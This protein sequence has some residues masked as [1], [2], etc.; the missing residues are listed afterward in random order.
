MHALRATTGAVL[1]WVNA[2]VWIVPTLVLALAALIRFVNLGHPSNLVF[3]EVYYVRDA[4]SQMIFGFPTEWPNDL[5]YAFGPEEL[6]RMSGEASYAVHPPLGKWLIA[7]GL[8]LFGADNGWGWRFSAALVGTLTVAL[9]MLLTHRLTRSVWVASL[10][11]L[12]L[13]IEG[14][15]VVLSRVSLLDGFLTFFALLG[16]LFMVLD[17]ERTQRRFRLD[18][19]QWMRASRTPQQPFPVTGRRWGPV[20]WWRPWLFAAA[21]AFGC[22]SAVKWSGLYFFLAFAVFTVIADVVTRRRLGIRH[23]LADGL[24]RQTPVA[25]LTTVPLLL[26]TYLASWSGWIFTSGGWNRS[27]ATE[28]GATDPDRTGQLAWLPDWLPSLW[29]YHV[30]MFDWHS[31]LQAAHPYLAHPLTWLPALRPTSMF[32]ET[33]HLGAE[34]CR[35]AECA[36]AITPIPNVLIWWGGVAAT[37]WLVVWLVRRSLAQRTLVRKF[38]TLQPF[39]PPRTSVTKQRFSATRFAPNALMLDRATVFALVGF[40]AGYAPWLITTSRT[41]VFQFYTVVF[42]PYLVLALTLVLWRLIVTGER[43]GGD[44]A[45]SRRWMVGVFLAATVLISAYF[46]PLWTGW[47]IPFAYWNIHMWL[48]GWR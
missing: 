36:M 47:P 43:A 33:S 4:A 6:A 48:P 11:G 23:W 19:R 46:L 39:L 45:L 25:A 14:V 26:V 35:F 7:I 40:L 2:H 1:G 15:S 9:L 38:E 24:L 22:A 18:A 30:D 31:T 12:L 3:D 41:A 29:N 21:I 37:V 10:A 28:T 13:G 27:W 32:F 34:G 5:G 17:L 42:A 20:F 44:I 8:A 16:V